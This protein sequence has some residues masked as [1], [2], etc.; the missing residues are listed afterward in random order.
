MIRQSL[1]S[2]S[3]RLA[4][5]SGTLQAV[6]PLATLDRGYAIVTN[7]ENGKITSDIGTVKPG[8]ETKTEIRNGFFYSNI[9]RVE[10]K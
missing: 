10:K 1:K 7:T 6:S 4:R 9:T 3:D 8:N 5:V 2:A